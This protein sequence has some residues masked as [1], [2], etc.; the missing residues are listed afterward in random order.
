[1]ASV[2]S[3]RLEDAQRAEHV[4]LGVVVGPLDRDAN[5]G[6]GGEVEDR[7]G[8]DR[9]EHLVGLPDVGDVQRRVAG[10]SLASPLR[11][12]VED[13]HLVA[14]RKQRVND[15]RAD[16]AGAPGHDRSHRLVS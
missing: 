3:R 14:A 10:D 9:V 16:E 11:E 12:I 1:M 7:L 13:V 6:L 15:V 4:D 2:P 5:V 8:L